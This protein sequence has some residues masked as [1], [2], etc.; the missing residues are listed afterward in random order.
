M[1]TRK[2]AEQRVREAQKAKTDDRFYRICKY[3]DHAI[4]TGRSTV[5]VGEAGIGKTSALKH[6]LEE[7]LGVKV[8]YLPLAQISPEDIGV[9]VPVTVEAGGVMDAK[10]ELRFL[11]FNQLIE[12]DD[13]YPNGKV[14]LLDEMN[15]ASKRTRA[16]AMELLNEHTIMGE[17]IPGLKAVIGLDNPVNYAGVSAGDFAQSTRVVTR[18]VTAND[19]PWREALTKK[20]EHR[21]LEPL[22][23]VWEE[24]PPAVR[25]QIPPRI[26]DFM[27]GN[28]DHG[29][30]LRWALPIFNF[31][32]A[33]IRDAAG[34]DVT[35]EVLGKIAVA[36]GA[37]VDKKVANKLRFACEAAI[38]QGVNMR[39]VGH[40]GVGKTATIKAV[41][42]EMGVELIYLSLSQVS[43]EHLGVPVPVDGKLEYL[44]WQRFLTP[45]RKVVVLDEFRRAP[46]QVRNA[47][48]ELIQERTLGGV[49]VPGLVSVIALDNP[50][51]GEGG[52]F[53]E[54]GELDPAQ[55][56]RFAINIPTEAK[57]V[58]WERYLLERYG[59][60]AKPFIDW[61]HERLDDEQRIIVNPRVVHMMVELYESSLELGDH[62][63]LEDALPVMP[64]GKRVDISLAHLKQALRGAAIV[65]LRTVL[66]NV[67]EWVAKITEEL[68]TRE[69]HN[70]AQVADLLGSAPLVTLEE[71]RDAVESLVAV[72]PKQFI[73]GLVQNQERQ[74]FWAELITA[75]SDRRKALMNE[76]RN[77]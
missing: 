77:R 54:T 68:E 55:A 53:Y 47:A 29:L 44:L 30:P 71:Y 4:R 22:F 36:L 15:R 46:M 43:S 19:I 67:D 72:L 60:I 34:K 32:N 66:N 5:F 25:S 45:G 49:G 57:D 23:Q 12:E 69:Y 17:P 52:M 20:Y 42:D 27:I 50:S 64:D 70:S 11:I 1:V 21:D 24:Q 18:F 73:I 6:Y 2:S 61:W 9:P 41:C 10:R 3:T 63:E 62:F 59:D 37:D 8:I 51:G 40:A 35:E 65:G 14:I 38:K 76:K 28:A 74:K 31:T 75:V 7:E 13:R 58:D 33:P 56:T 48:M 26:L 39:A 16:A